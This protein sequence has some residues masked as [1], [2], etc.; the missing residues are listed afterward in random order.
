VSTR[1]SK[2]LRAY[3][4]TKNAKIQAYEARVEALEAQLKIYMV[5]VANVD[6]GG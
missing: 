3:E 4:D 2:P 6:N 1:R 5:V